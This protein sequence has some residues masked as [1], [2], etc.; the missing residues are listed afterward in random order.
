MEVVS[1]VLTASSNAARNSLNPRLYE[2]FLW[3]RSFFKK[4]IGHSADH[5]SSNLPG[6]AKSLVNRVVTIDP[7]GSSLLHFI[8]S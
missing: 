6:I 4:P 7:E 1:N 8:N 2:H 5:A 3:N